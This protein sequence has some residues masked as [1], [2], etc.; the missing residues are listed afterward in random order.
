M[1]YNL[2]IKPTLRLYCLLKW[3]YDMS[4]QLSFIMEIQT[5]LV[6][7]TIFQLYSYTSSVWIDQ[8]YKYLLHSHIWNLLNFISWG[9][10]HK[11]PKKYNRM[12]DVTKPHWARR[13]RLRTL[14]FCEGACVQQWNLYRDNS[15]NWKQARF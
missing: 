14:S 1:V 15:K 10:L 7:G 4:F 8:Y 3:N 6:L 5:N 13:V 11:P 2:I 9:S 12:C